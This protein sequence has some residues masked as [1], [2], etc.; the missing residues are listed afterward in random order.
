[1][2]SGKGEGASSSSQIHLLNIDGLAHEDEEDDD[3]FIDHGD[4]D[5]D[6]Q[7]ESKPAA[8]SSMVVRQQACKTT[9]AGIN[10]LTPVVAVEAQDQDMGPHPIATAAVVFLKPRVF[11]PLQLNAAEGTSLE[12]T[13]CSNVQ[14]YSL[15]VEHYEAVRS[16]VGGHGAV[17]LAFGKGAT[18]VAPHSQLGD[19]MAAVAE[20]PPG[21][22]HAG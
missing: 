16:D 20:A 22:R 4:D 18:A 11:H 7:A 6:E 3:T 8:S 21:R 14:I 19:L 15:L 17:V 10:S 1:M 2:Y 9:G 13:W 12:G 5:D